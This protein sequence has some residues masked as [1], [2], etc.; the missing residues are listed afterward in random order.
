MN[1]CNESLIYSE[2]SN[3]RNVNVEYPRYQ[4]W[5]IIRGSSLGRNSSSTSP[6]PK[7][8]EAAT[9]SSSS[10]KKQSSSSSKKSKRLFKTNY[11]HYIVMTL[12]DDKYLPLLKQYQQLNGKE[13][14]LT[15][16]ACFI[17]LSGYDP[18]RLISNM[19]IDSFEDLKKLKSYNN[20]LTD[21]EKQRASV[22]NFIW[23]Y[24]IAIN[25]FWHKKPRGGGDYQRSRN[26]VSGFLKWVQSS[27]LQATYFKREKEKAEKKELEIKEKKAQKEKARKERQ[28]KKSK[29]KRVKLNVETHPPSSTIKISTL[30]SPKLRTIYD[31]GSNIQTTCNLLSPILPQT[32]K[33]HDS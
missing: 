21:F 1:V 31:G 28:K 6:S 29:S 12:P 4:Q 15:R 5:G 8:E 2:S 22:V 20:K 13:K 24:Q 25:Q 3:C 33:F 23:N 27:E 11:P 9:S 19:G 7:P 32:I 18:D 30:A 10:P 26:A 14:H 17:P 16:Y